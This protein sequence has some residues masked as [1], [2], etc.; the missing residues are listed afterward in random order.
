MKDLLSID[1]L[2]RSAIEAILD[3]AERFSEVTNREIAKVPALR[4]RTVASLFFED[5]TRTRLSFETAAKRLSADTMTFNVGTSSVSKGESLRDTVRT[6]TRMGVDALVV[7]HHHAGV[8]HQI[9]GWVDAAVINAGDGRHEHPT[10]AL[11]DLFTIRRRRDKDLAGTNVVIVGDLRHSRVARS[12]VKALAT[13]G[14][15][16]TIVAPP[17]LMPADLETWPANSVDNIDLVLG[18]AD[19][20]YLLR[21]QHERRRDA[22][23]GGLREYHDRYAMTSDRLKRCRPDVLVMHPGPVNRGVE[24]DADVADGSNSVI[25]EQVTNGVPVRM[26]VLYT[27]LGGS[28]VGANSP[29]SSDAARQ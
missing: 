25:G 2:D 10:Q 27:L 24:L 1:D 9:A 21:L 14:A 16:I 20:V 4:G 28:G 15:N 17:T 29:I 3:L 22:L 12:E 5:S 26:A 13:V 8:P 6:I 19:V 11:L 18:D 23:P 7:R